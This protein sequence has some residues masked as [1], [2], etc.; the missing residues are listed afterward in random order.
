MV[1]ILRLF[2]A[3]FIIYFIN[4]IFSGVIKTNCDSALKVICKEDE[5][6][7]KEYAFVG[8]RYIRKY[9]FI[10]SFR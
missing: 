10:S 5:I 4:T 9:G 2:S 1:D 3:A 7:E 6:K 8:S